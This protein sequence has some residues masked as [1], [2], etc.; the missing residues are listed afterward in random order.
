MVYE[1]FKKLEFLVVAD[2][3]M[4]PTANMADIVLPVAANLE[5]NDLLVRMNYAAAIPKV[6]DPP[7]ECRSDLQWI[8]EIA[9]AM[10]YADIFWPD[11]SAAMDYILKP[12]G[13]NYEE[14]KN[15]GVIWSADEFRKHERQ[16]FRTPSGKVE[17]YSSRLEEMG[18]DP[19]PVYRDQL[20]VS[21]GAL[22]KPGEYPLVLTN[23]KSYYYYHSSHRNIPSLR[24]LSPEPVAHLHPVT[25]EKLGLSQGDMVYIETSNGKIKQRIEGNS[26]LDPRVVL[27]AYGWWFPEH[28]PLDNY[29]WEE[30]NIN[31]LT[32]NVP[33]FDPALGTPN[34][35][36]LMCKITR[37]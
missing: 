27:V 37:A 33:P 36:G 13:L 3:F 8:N 21:N 15:K 31:I 1:A 6:L 23:F 14:V 26:D 32:S 24:K 20:E 35:R 12:T 10:G 2:L 7:G 30:A 22:E 5:Y 29:G 4:T 34:L 25:M 11:E 9:A 18:L 17:F 28:G 16:G 19:L